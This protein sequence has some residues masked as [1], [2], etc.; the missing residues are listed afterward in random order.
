M[1]YRS[2]RQSSLYRLSLHQELLRRQQLRAK[3]VP[4]P[5][6]QDRVLKAARLWLPL[7]FAAVAAF[8]CWNQLFA[9]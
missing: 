1:S 2:A 9:R 7:T 5:R 4:M 8:A 3:A 6:P